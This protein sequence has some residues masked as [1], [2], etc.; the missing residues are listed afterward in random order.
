MGTRMLTILADDLTGAA[1]CGL[2]AA[3]RGL[4]TVVALT[5]AAH[6]TDVVARDLDTRRGD[7]GGAYAATCAA[8]PRHGAL[9]LKIDS[10]LRGH[11]G[12]AI[13][14]ALDAGAGDVAVVAPAFPAQGRTVIGGRLRVDGREV[15]DLQGLLR[16]QS[17]HAARPGA[18]VAADAASEDDLRRVVAE[19]RGGGARVVW[20]GSAGLAAALAEALAAGGAPGELPTADGP[21]ITVV[22]TAAAGAAAQLEALLARPGVEAVGDSA[23]A[24]R[25]ALRAGADP[26]VHAARPD[27][28][29]RP[30]LARA[31]AAAVAEG[32]AGDP[33][34]GL[35]LTGG[36]TARAVCE[37]LGIE[38]VEL[39]GEVEP[40]VPAGRAVG[41]PAAVVTKA[42]AFGDPRSLVRAHAALTARRPCP[43]R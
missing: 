25:R 29:L 36:E 21:V 17:R 1:D 41:H 28:D 30:A 32:C 2:Q 14:A 18:V 22:G 31:L 35:V 10:T 20:V 37:A 42:G 5:G 11:V 26:V 3:R 13:D 6:D 16:A 8:I 24:L 19:H 33:P 39:A 15:A 7:A 38:A 9:Y 4:R 23:P 43:A 34:A 40:G 12:A 27:G